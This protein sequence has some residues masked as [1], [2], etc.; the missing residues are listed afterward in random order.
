MKRRGLTLIELV[1]IMMILAILAAVAVP[2]YLSSQKD[3]AMTQQ[4]SW[5]KVEGTT[6]E[7]SLEFTANDLSEAQKVIQ[8]CLKDNPGTRVDGNSVQVKIRLKIKND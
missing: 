8:A 5:H 3:Q 1:I 4:Y 7:Y 2:H 6:D